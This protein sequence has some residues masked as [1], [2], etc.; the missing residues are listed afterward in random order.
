MCGGGG[1]GGGAIVDGDE[2]LMGII[3]Y[4]GIFMVKC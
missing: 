3:S 1:G 4:H 2:C